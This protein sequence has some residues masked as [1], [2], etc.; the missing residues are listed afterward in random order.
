MDPTRG[1]VSV[2]DSP[3]RCWEVKFVYRNCVLNPIVPKTTSL[4][5]PH[6]MLAVALWAL[7]EQMLSPHQEDTSPTN[8]AWRRRI[9]PKIG[10]VGVHAAA[11][12][13]WGVCHF[14]AAC[15]PHVVARRGSHRDGPLAEVRLPDE[16]VDAHGDTTTR[17]LLCL[18]QHRLHVLVGVLDRNPVAAVEASNLMIC[19]VLQLASDVVAWAT[20]KTTASL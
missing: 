14:P 13:T 5:K 15:T 19:S 7:Q 1:E 6:D 4:S 10:K 18:A 11:A 16:R 8:N 3:I 12:P 20:T 17:T 2:L 9:A